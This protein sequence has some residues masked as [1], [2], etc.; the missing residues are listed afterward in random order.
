MFIPGKELCWTFVLQIHVLKKFY[1][2][3]CI[4]IHL[5]IYIFLGSWSLKMGPI[6][7]LET[8]ANNYHYTLHNIAEEHSSSLSCGA[9]LKSRKCTHH[10]VRNCLMLRK[11]QKDNT[12]I[13]LRESE[14]S[15]KN[16]K[17]LWFMYLKTGVNLNYTSFGISQRT[18]IAIIKTEI[19]FGEVIRVNCENY[20][21]HCVH[22]M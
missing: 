7:C 9:S 12:A 20:T 17:Q 16:L 21:K 1:S 18:Y 15:R 22:K 4:G 10:L 3:S 6:S 13:N 5:F 14:R 11:S 2:I 8:S 19:V